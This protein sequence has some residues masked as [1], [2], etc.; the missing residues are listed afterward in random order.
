MRTNIFCML[1]LLI[2]FAASSCRKGKSVVPATPPPTDT[3]NVMV[4]YADYTALKTGN[5]WIYQRYWLDSANG[6]A[7][8]EG[9]YDSAYVEKDTMIGKHLYHKY[10]MIA[11][12]TSITVTSFLR[13]SQSY[14]VNEAGVISFSS[15]DFTN[16][17][18]TYA[19]GPNATTSQTLIITEKMGFRHATTIV[20]AGSFT[21]STFRK[22]SKYPPGAMWD[23]RECHYKYAKN[24]G[25]VSESIHYIDYPMVMERRLVR[26]K[27]K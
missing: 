22:I 11:L 20:E 26:Y 9:K 24:T 2:A 7:H 19:Y 1:V 13:D 15:T 8:P 25:M 16:T 18:R 3:T 5:Y 23:T 14:T 4:Q 21:T 17:F 10:C 27:V 12:P 6:E